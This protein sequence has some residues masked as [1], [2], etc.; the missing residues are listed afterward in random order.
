MDN[1]V[2]FINLAPKVGPEA[3][4]AGA[5][6]F[7]TALA[8][9]SVKI[10]EKF[11]EQEKARQQAIAEAKKQKD[12]T[13]ASIRKEVEKA[14]RSAGG[15]LQE[16]GQDTIDF[17]TNSKALAE[18]AI[19]AELMLTPPYSDSYSPEELQQAQTQVDEFYSYINTSKAAGGKIEAA[20]TAANEI[21][22][23]GGLPDHINGYTNNVI[24]LLPGGINSAQDFEKNNEYNIIASSY[25]TE[26]K[27]LPSGWDVT[28][29]NES[30]KGQSVTTY[31]FTGANNEEFSYSI[32]GSGKPLEFAREIGD[33]ALFDAT[34]TIKDEKTGNISDRFKYS[35]TTASKEGLG[36]G[37]ERINEQQFVNMQGIKTEFK[38]QVRGN[39]QGAFLDGKVGLLNYISYNV[40]KEELIDQVLEIYNNDESD[41]AKIN[42]LTDLVFN[43][44]F[45]DLESKYN[46]REASEEEIQQAQTNGVELIKNEDGIPMV[47]SEIDYGKPKDTSK[48]G[49]SG[50]LSAKQEAQVAASDSATRL[51]EGKIEGN[52]IQVKGL[53]L[54]KKDGKVFIKDYGSYQGLSV[55]KDTFKKGFS[56][57]L[58]LKQ[59]LPDIFGPLTPAERKQL[60]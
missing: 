5:A 34:R 47:Y 8:G 1:Q 49:D 23:S 18:K 58:N 31:T 25:F 35:S 42:E 9:A 30:I 6:Q 26:G 13:R 59:A 32:D 19:E 2:D 17:D 22:N 51:F 20:V 36:D 44:M 3:I 60:Q 12:K 40:G 7:A 48:T 57:F 33:D 4:A 15:A 11:A 43:P 41:V 39:I 52:E 50:S 37:L 28:S 16:K 14:R 45:K 53:Q 55:A 10:G 38:D 54:V 27:V 21:T 46:P 56:N 24:E 29:K